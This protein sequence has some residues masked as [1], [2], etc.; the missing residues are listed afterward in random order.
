MLLTAWWAAHK[1]TWMTAGKLIDT[2][3][4]GPIHSINQAISDPVHEALLEVAADN[5]NQI[6]RNLLGWYLRRNAGRI[7][8]G[9]KLEPKNRTGEKSRASR[10]YRVVKI[11]T[12]AGKP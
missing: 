10:E 2:P 9:Y 3:T 7:A 4:G 5:R 12:T 6:S 1:N 11:S 8:G